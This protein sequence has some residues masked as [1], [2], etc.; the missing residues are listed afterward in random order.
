MESWAGELTARRK[1]GLMFDVHL[2]AN[3]VVNEAG[4]PIQ[5]MASFI[6]VTERRKAEEAL[7]QSEE[8][9]RLVVENASDAIMVIQEL[10]IKFANTR[11]AEITGYSRDELIAKPFIDMVHP[12]DQAMVMES[13][14][15]RLRGEDVPSVYPFR[16][17]TKNGMVKWAE[18][19]AVFIIWQA[20]PVVLSFLSDITERVLAEEALRESERKYRVLFDEAA[21]SIAIID[22]EGHLLDVNKR[23]EE[24]SGWSREEMIGKNVFTLGLLTKSSVGEGGLI[25]SAGCSMI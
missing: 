9:Y 19:R 23:F 18:V 5:L 11:T 20:G 12:D 3:A 4:N 7:R 17:M 6:D 22:I 10:K 2:S 16:F 1:D 14:L 21:D 25:T 13:H 8:N 24:E 15:K